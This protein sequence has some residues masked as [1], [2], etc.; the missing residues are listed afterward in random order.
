MCSEH[1][2]YCIEILVCICF[3]RNS[4]RI[5][6]GH[7]VTWPIFTGPDS[8]WCFPTLTPC[9]NVFRVLNVELSKAPYIPLSQNLETVWNSMV[10]HG[11]AWWRDKK[12]GRGQSWIWIFQDIYPTTSGHPSLVPCLSFNW[13]MDTLSHPWYQLILLLYSHLYFC[14][15]NFGEYA[16]V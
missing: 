12:Q 3:S 4:S 5:A 7:F 6:S 13:S 15:V 14:K 1:L 10:L 9:Q 11:L 2:S 16:W 8:Q